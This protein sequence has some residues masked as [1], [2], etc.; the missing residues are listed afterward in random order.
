[1]V[2]ACR[3]SCQPAARKQVQIRTPRGNPPAA[4]FVPDRTNTFRPSIETLRTELAPLQGHSG[5]DA[6]QFAAPAGV[7]PSGHD[8]RARL[9]EAQMTKA[10]MTKAQGN[11]K[12]QIPSPSF[13]GALNFSR[14]IFPFALI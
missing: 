14:F 13:V 9:A 6:S 5:P 10:R 12:N 2:W 11:P 8:Q 3:R 7:V 4:R 1:M